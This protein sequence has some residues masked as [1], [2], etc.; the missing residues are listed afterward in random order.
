MLP[1]SYGI[2]INLT[3]AVK[4]FN[5]RMLL[6]LP[7]RWSFVLAFLFVP[8]ELRGL[9]KCGCFRTSMYY[10]SVAGSPCT[11]GMFFILYCSSMCGGK[12]G[13]FQV[14]LVWG[15]RFVG[16]VS[17]FCCSFYMWLYW[18][19]MRGWFRP[20]L[21]GAFY[22]LL[23]VVMDFRLVLWIFDFCGRPD[24]CCVDTA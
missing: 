3:N 2:V 5:L 4:S 13:E 21:L 15:G 14:I 18:S 20:P 16:M 11:I 12:R 22:L 6:Q 17:A 7:G 24:D 23:F 1:F 19:S 10:I 8:L 9:P